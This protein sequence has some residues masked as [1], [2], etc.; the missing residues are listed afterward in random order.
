[1]KFPRIS[2]VILSLCAFA[3]CDDEQEGKPMNSDLSGET[4]ATIL[5]Y[6][7]ENKGW[8]ESVYGITFN[9]REGDLHAYWVVHKDDL[10]SITLGC[11]KSMELLFDPNTGKI[12]EERGFQ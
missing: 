2:L 4:L 1:M 8:T 12:I 7:E 6:V 11:G 9:R 5:S 3:A 10:K